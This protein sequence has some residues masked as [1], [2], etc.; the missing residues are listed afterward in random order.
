[1]S[2]IDVNDPRY[3]GKRAPSNE[4]LTRVLATII[5]KYGKFSVEANGPT[6]TATFRDDDSDFSEF[7]GTVQLDSEVEG[8]NVVLRVSFVE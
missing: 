8:E 2:V 4:Q 6:F 7:G 5:R 3:A 1:M